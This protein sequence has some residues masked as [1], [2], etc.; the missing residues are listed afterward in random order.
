MFLTASNDDKLVTIFIE[1]YPFFLP[2]KHIHIYIYQSKPDIFNLQQHSLNTQALNNIP[3]K[4]IFAG[5]VKTK[6]QST[7]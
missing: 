3:E 5:T 6:F 1:S 4:T 2:P 7:F